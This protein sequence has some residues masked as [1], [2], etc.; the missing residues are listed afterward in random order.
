MRQWSSRRVCEVI[1]S[2]HLNQF[3]IRLH[4][5]DPHITT[6]LQLPFALLQP[7][8]IIYDDKLE[9]TRIRLEGTKTD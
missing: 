1:N 7:L 4:F 6:D 8:D 5:G 3:L 2:S 9:E